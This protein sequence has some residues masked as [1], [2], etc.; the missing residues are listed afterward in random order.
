VI[1]TVSR[2]EGASADPCPFPCLCGLDCRSDPF[3]RPG[4]GTRSDQRDHL[5]RPDLGR[6]GQPCGGADP[7]MDGHFAHLAQARA[8]LG[9]QSLRS[10]AGQPKSLFWLRHEAVVDALS[11]RMGAG[12]VDGRTVGRGVKQ[13][14]ASATKRL[15]MDCQ[16]DL[17]P[18][19]FRGSPVVKGQRARKAFTERSDV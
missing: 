16:A 19:V 13:P 17:G 6:P 3:L 18:Y 8:A 4:R 1:S 7:R 5:Q 9:L 14:F 12:C 11:F 2:T 15:R 10:R